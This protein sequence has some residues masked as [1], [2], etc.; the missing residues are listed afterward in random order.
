MGNLYIIVNHTK[1]EYIDPISKFRELLFGTWSAV[2]LMLL[3]TGY[4]QGKWSKDSIELVGD[5]NMKYYEKILN[6]YKDVTKEMDYYLHD[7]I[8]EKRLG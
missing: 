3:Q 4:N 1:K 2:L 6:E 5:E 8:E 7:V